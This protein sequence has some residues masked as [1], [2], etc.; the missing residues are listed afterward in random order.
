MRL[1]KW[2]GGL[3]GLA[4]L[5]IAGLQSVATTIVVVAGLV[6]AGV[7]W[8]WIRRPDVAASVVS[9]AATCVLTSE[10]TYTIGVR[11]EAVSSLQLGYAFWLFAG[12]IAATA[13]L[14]PRHRGARAVTI[15]Y[16]HA[17]LVLASM[18]ASFAPA[19][20]PVLGLLVGIGLVAW[21]SR[22]RPWRAIQR[23]LG[24]QRQ[25]DRSDQVRGADRTHEILGGEVIRRSDA[26]YLVET[27]RWSG[28]VDRAI[29]NG[30][31][32][33]GL[34]GDPAALGAR[35]EPIVNDIR[36]FRCANGFRGDEV[37]GLVVFWDDT[38]LPEPG[39]LE[40]AVADTRVVLVRGAELS[41]W[42][43]DQVVDDDRG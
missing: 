34:D 23:R 6:V 36:R 18:L 4:A 25:P 3:L 30:V 24:R 33:Y 35:L 11:L 21:R 15:A 19:A 20:I 7:V 31:E 13:W 29:E 42:S 10:I 16:A 28:R 26:I 38:E 9:L 32:A 41:A 39:G 37:R 14:A 12:V 22:P 2:L 27:R 17:V 1:V 8:W 5:L 40:V 43:G